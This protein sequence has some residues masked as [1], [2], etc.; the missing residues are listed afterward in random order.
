MEVWVTADHHFWHYRIIEYENR[1]FKCIDAMN[2]SMV[3]EWND[4]ISEDDI[5]FHLGDVSFGLVDD[6]I[7]L[8]QKLKGKKVLIRGNHDYHR[9]HTFWK[10]A[11]FL[12]VTDDPIYLGEIVLS[13]EPLGLRLLPENGI[14]V[15]GHIHSKHYVEIRW[16]P[17]YR[18]VG[19]DV[20]GFK[21]VKLID[22]I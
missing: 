18:N 10:R 8:C 12:Y 14:N 15:H 9:T 2:N 17:Y 11:G 22:I 21:P 6:T 5:V 16:H 1:P 20:T 19:V 13:H 7:K 4:H 3:G